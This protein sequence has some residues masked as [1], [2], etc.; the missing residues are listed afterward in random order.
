M[1]YLIIILV[2][3][4]NI[5]GKRHINCS[6]HIPKNDNYERPILD[7]TIVSPSGHFMIHYND[8]R[9]NIEDYAHEVGI[10]AD[11][12]RAFII[13]SL[14]F[15]AEIPDDDG[16]YDIYIMQLN[17]GEYGINIPEQKEEDV[18][19][20]GSSWVEIDDDFIGNLYITTGLDAMK[21]T[22]AHEFFHAIQRAYAPFHGYNS[23][24][25]ELSS[26]WIEDLIYPDV[27]D[28]IEFSQEG[29]DYFESPYSNMNSYKGYGLG[30]YGHY[31]NYMFD[32]DIMRYIW[33]HVDDLKSICIDI[34]NK[35][36]CRYGDYDFCRWIDND[37]ELDKEICILDE[38][39]NDLFFN[40]IDSVLSA[41]EFGNV[42]FID[43]WLD[44][45][46]RN[47]FNGYFNDMNNDVY[48][49]QDQKYFNPIETNPQNISLSDTVD[50]DLNNKSIAIKSFTSNEYPY[51][52]NFLGETSDNAQGA[53]S[54][55]S[56]SDYAIED[57]DNLDHSYISDTLD[58]RH[59]SHIMY[60]SNSK[61]PDQLSGNIFSNIIDLNMSREIVI[62]PNPLAQSMGHEISVRI[63]NGV[64]AD[65]FS[66]KLYNIEG[67]FIKDI[68][69]GDIDY[70]LDPFNEFKI[71]LF[72]NNNN[73]A[74]GVYI[75][76]FNIDGEI[77]NK[78]I[79]YLK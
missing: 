2:L 33:E 66:I 63:N 17:N 59:T 4:A 31:I 76:S 5:Y 69:L 49:Y 62:F 79:V 42:S 6:E 35:I 67:R 45:N 40:S 30:L 71:S 21:I 65:Q 48:Y 73:M 37:E 77:K 60:I 16:I 41:P 53:I 44:F 64:E 54:I 43:T 61:F 29:D 34:D 15:K 68:N 18:Y 39:N 26:V 28:Y 22:V 23:F 14:G 56:D 1:R 50:F 58:Y 47:L 78:K 3:F 46:V 52:F 24:F 8:Y 51:E 25:Y 36:D 75:L 12:S 27:N 11:K 32:D 57:L 7:H 10:A 74:S 19:Y 9:I 20:D 72:N 38:Y 55:I 13:D 70:T